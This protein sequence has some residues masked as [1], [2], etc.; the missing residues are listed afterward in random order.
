MN[1]NNSLSLNLKPVNDILVIDLEE[2]LIEFLFIWFP[3]R[4]FILAS[5][6]LSTAYNPIK[7]SGSLN[8]QSIF[9]LYSEKYFFNS[10]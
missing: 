9:V 5:F 4:N 1:S 2:W 3:G 8:C 6:V 7:P 10:E